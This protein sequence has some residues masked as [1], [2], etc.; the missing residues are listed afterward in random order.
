MKKI[1]HHF[2]VYKLIY[3]IATISVLL[4]ITLA[5]SIDSIRYTKYFPPKTVEMSPREAYN[6]MLSNPGGYLFFDVRSKSEYDNLH[7]S[8]SISFPI[9]N[10]YDQWPTLPR[11]GKKIYLICTTG[12]LAGIAYGY[13]QL[14]GF[15]NI[16]LI[17]GGIQNW[18]GQGLPS[19]A[20]PMFID[21]DGTLDNPDVVSVSPCLQLQS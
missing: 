12:R 9:A 3:I 4:G 1:I 20:K 8:S 2:S 18:V 7:A 16:V 15:R 5:V 21:K 6:E 13:L 19:V 11:S 10:L 14:H 17:Q